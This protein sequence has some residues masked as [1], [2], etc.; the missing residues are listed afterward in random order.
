MSTL[1]RR[2]S[3]PAGFTLVELLVVIAIIGTLVALLLP[4]VQRARETARQ[5]QCMNNLK[6]IGLALVAF[7]TSKQR[8]PG[9]A[10]VVKRAN[11]VWVMG[12]VNTENRI[13]VENTDDIDEAWNISW[14]AMILPNMDRQD[15]WDQLLNQKVA[16]LEPTPTNEGILEIRP[17]E[18]YVCPSDTDAKSNVN[19]AALSYIANTGAWDRDTAG[20]FLPIDSTGNGK[21]DT[22]DNGLFQNQAA[23]VRNNQTPPQMQIS[24]IRDGASTTIMVSENDN[25]N[26][27][28]LANGDPYFTWLGGDG[29]DFGT[30]Q[31]LG[32][33][34]VVAENPQPGNL[35]TNQERI[36]R[37]ASTTFSPT[38]PNLA[39]PA[40]HHTGGVNVV[41]ADGHTQYLRED[42]DYLV[43]QRLITPNGRKCVDPTDWTNE[44]NSPT[45]VIYKFRTAPPLSEADYQ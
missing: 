42:V 7:D 1:S 15:I 6:Q 36:N 10:Q 11:N 12:G 21:G 9:Y 29:V 5:T 4:A 30:E 37:E 26:Y 2:S 19:L 17:I 25:K 3:R 18:A 14:A 31:Q 44:T 28:P 33:V 41:Y 40:S 22:T 35:I 20:M 23:Y 43:Y 27:D 24:K 34:W 8:L 38:T 39:R 32:L 13:E 16:R 45:G